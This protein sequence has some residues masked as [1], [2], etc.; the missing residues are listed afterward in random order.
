MEMIK[1]DFNAL[2]I[3]RAIHDIERIKNILLTDEQK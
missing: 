3:L 2:R 1:Q